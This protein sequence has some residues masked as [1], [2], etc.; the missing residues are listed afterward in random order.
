MQPNGVSVTSNR[1]AAKDTEALMFLE[2]AL[3]DTPAVPSPRVRVAL[4]SGSEYHRDLQCALRQVQRHLWTLAQ[5]GVP[6][7]HVKLTYAA[8]GSFRDFCL[9]ETSGTAAFA[10]VFALICQ[11]P[12]RDTLLSNAH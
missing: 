5:K 10:A 9:E 2:V 4:D 11:M 8:Y 3:P 1:E 12:S 6:R 7:S